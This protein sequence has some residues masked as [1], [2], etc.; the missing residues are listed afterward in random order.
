MGADYPELVQRK[1]VV[2]E[3]LKQEE[4][5]FFETL[6][7]GLNLLDDA[8]SKIGSSQILGAE[9]VFKLYDTFG[10][11]VDLTALIAREKNIQIDE[12]GFQKLMQNQQEM[13][14]K[15]WKGSGEFSI[16]P[17]VKEWKSKN[18]LPKFVGYE[19]D[20]ESNSKVVAIEKISQ[21]TA[22]VAI[23]P[24]PFYGEG[25]G[26]VGDLGQVV[27]LSTQKS[28]SVI[29]TQKPYEG[30]LALLVKSDSGAID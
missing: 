25:G 17:A 27:S 21:D 16:S 4:E 29:D 6:G 13:S 10:F 24:C 28:Y 19:K 3:I 7:K 11:P 2:Q 14:R 20:L 15:S 22:W 23:D 30:G 5:K 26:Q 12:S 18:I 1:S 8:F 9:T